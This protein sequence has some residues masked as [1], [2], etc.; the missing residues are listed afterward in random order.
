[1]TRIELIGTTP[2]PFPDR[3]RLPLHFDPARLLADLERLRDV[4]W[5]RHFVE[6]NY[7][8]DWSVIPLRAQAGATHPVMMMYPAPTA[9]AF[10]DTPFLAQTPYI[11][12]ILR[13][14]EC[15]LRCVRLMRLTPGSLIREHSDHDLAAELGAVRLHVPITSNPGV[16]FRLNGARVDMVPGSLWY[17]RLSD[18]HS[19][20]NDGDDDR[21]HLVIDTTPNAWLLTMLERGASL[22]TVNKAGPG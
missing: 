11:R 12:E 18:P 10:E 8:G 19:V 14:F 16:D 2:M 7:Q 4:E 15:E 5:L 13:G 1:M 22:N 20:R 3:I 9:V 21:V 17:L 6:G